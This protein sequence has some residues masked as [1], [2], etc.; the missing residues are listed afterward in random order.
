MTVVLGPSTLMDRALPSG[1][2]F[3]YVSQWKMQ[4]GVSY[5]QVAQILVT[6]AGTVN[7]DMVAKWGWLFS[8][9]ENI[10]V[11]YPQGNTAAP[12]PRITDDTRPKPVKA[13]LI[14]HMVEENFNGDAIAGSR[15][16]WERARSEQIYATA[17]AIIER[18]VWRFE[19]DLLNRFFLNTEYTIGSGG[20]NVPFVRGNGGNVDYIP[21]SYE[22]Q[23]FDATHNHFIGYNASTP[24]T[25]ADVL[26]GLAAELAHHGH[27]PPFRAM[28][29]RTDVDAGTFNALTN[30]IRFVNV[31]GGLIVAGGSTSNP[32]FI[33]QTTYDYDHVADFQTNNGIVQLYATS[34]VPT[35]YV[36]MAKSYGQLD[37]RNPLVVYTYPGKGFGVSVVPQTVANE[38]VPISQIDLEFNFG[39]GVG[40]DRTNGAVGYLVAGGTYANPTIS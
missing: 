32:Q 13:N 19:L 18:A 16:F 7:E 3:G 8:F 23:N 10:M 14:G 35:G 31:A 24:K 11:E 27:K 12:M 2:D 5:G 15:L 40:K 25:F 34:R 37:K 1:I 20:Y 29:S 22:G 39:V 36:G 28:V 26:N 4:D 38:E 21:F 9:T 17:G 30:I 6:A 33:Q